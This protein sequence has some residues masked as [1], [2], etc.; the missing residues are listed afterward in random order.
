MRSA[1]ILVGVVAA[2]AADADRLLTAVLFWNLLINLSYFAVAGVIAK[3]LADC[4]GSFATK[5]LLIA[6]ALSLHVRS[7]HDKTVQSHFF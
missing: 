5:Q 3:K 7:T 2:L 1:T 6:Y 4:N